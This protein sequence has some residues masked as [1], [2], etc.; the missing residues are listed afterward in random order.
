MILAA[1]III[2]IQDIQMTGLIGMTIYIL[3]T[4]VLSF[5]FNLFLTIH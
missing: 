5:D 3:I 4:F 2:L 1:M